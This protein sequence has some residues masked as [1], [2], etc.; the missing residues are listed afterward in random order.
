MEN[1]QP[2]CT[3]LCLCLVRWNL[4]NALPVT[5]SEVELLVL[6]NL[7]YAGGVCTGEPCESPITKVFSSDVL[8]MS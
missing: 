5:Y 2:S 8:G 7:T 1:S 4:K 6:L 3:Y